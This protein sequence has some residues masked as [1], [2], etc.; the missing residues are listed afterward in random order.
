MLYVFWPEGPKIQKTVPS[1]TDEGL[2]RDVEKHLV[3]IVTV[4]THLC[5]KETCSNNTILRT[6]TNIYIYIY[7]YIY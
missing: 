2:C 6:Y 3:K 1:N 4:S 7:I 5:F